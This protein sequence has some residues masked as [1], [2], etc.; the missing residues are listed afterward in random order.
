MEDFEIEFLTGPGPGEDPTAAEPDF[1]VAPTKAAPVVLERRPRGEVM[2]VE[3]AAE[4]SV[5]GAEEEDRAAQVEFAAEPAEPEP[6]R[7]LRLLTWGLVPSWAK[8]RS[9]GSRMINAR[10]ET[11]LDRTHRRAALTRR[12][13]VPA[14]GWYEWQASPTERDRRG[15]PRKQP[16]YLHPV[17]GG[18][19]AF[20]GIYEFWR[21]PAV[22]AD[23]PGA[24]LTTYAVITTDAEEPLR[25]VHDRMPLVLPPDR[26]DAWLDPKLQDADAVRALLAPPPAGR[27]AATAVTTRVNAA[28]NNGPGLIEPAPLDSLHGVIDPVTGEL[29]GG[30]DA[31]F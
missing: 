10:S 29:I 16:F 20:A 23:D 28:T 6:V 31:L 21:D 15:K 14:D 8:D 26:W 9:V 1:N 30:G 4:S 3:S 17:L 24:W 13:L 18:P 25:S 19:I 22:H 27:F 11:L 7:W 5:E 2:A 12:C